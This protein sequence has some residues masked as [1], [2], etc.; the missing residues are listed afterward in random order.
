MNTKENTNNS[1][2][3]YTFRKEH[4]STKYGG[5]KRLPGHVLVEE[6]MVPAYPAQLSHL[7]NRTG[8]PYKRLQ[9]LIR[10]K[11][12]IDGRMA[13]ALGSFFG[14]G[15]DYWNELQAKYERGEAL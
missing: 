7:A 14:N 6:F 4:T 10:G 13:D 3:T 5:Y 15:A 11:D 1:E 12:R 2:R 8:I 9:N